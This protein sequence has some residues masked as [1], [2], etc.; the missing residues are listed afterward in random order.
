MT[1][2]ETF[3]DMLK[4]FKPA[5]AAGIN[6]TLQWNITGDKL[7]RWAISIREQSCELIQGGVEK[8]DIVFQANEKDWLSI[9]SG[10]LDPTMAFMTGKVKIVGDMSLAIKIPGLF[11]TQRRS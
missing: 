9:S 5:K 1:I 11:P 3:E 6:K 4:S 7:E 2:N 10:T 8:P